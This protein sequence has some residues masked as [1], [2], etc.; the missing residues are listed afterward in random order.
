MLKDNTTF[1]KVQLTKSF[2]TYSYPEVQNEKEG[3]L[4]LRDQMVERITRDIVGNDFSMYNII[5]QAL[6]QALMG[7]HKVM[8]GEM[9]DI[10][11]RQIVASNL[12]LDELKDIYKFISDQLQKIEEPFSFREAA[13]NFLPHIFQAPK[14]L[15]MTALLKES[16]QAATCIVAFVGR[17]HVSPIQ[18]SWVPPPNGI[19][20]TEATR[21]AERRL[22]ETNEELIE[23]HALLD[24]LLEKR[25]WGQKYIQNP[26]PYITNDITKVSPD[27]LKQ[28]IDCF[29]FHYS[30]YEA[31]KR[32]IKTDFQI[33]TFNS[34]KLALME[35]PFYDERLKNS[36]SQRQ[37]TM[38]L[39]MSSSGPGSTRG[40]QLKSFGRKIEKNKLIQ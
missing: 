32:K 18:N 25:P 38:N 6:Y 20:M 12:T 35:N 10:L 4:A 27:K 40:I 21:I 11:H 33:P 14:D 26:F 22:G 31:F 39:L 36:A 17:H 2:M 8:L 1:D 16:F 28:Y 30:K 3:G 34:R 19:N 24:S 13:F 7:K 37:E 9:P 23:K 29:Q 5:N 15:Y